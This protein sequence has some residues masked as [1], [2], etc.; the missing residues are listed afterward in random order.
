M[1]C[2]ELF[3]CSPVDDD[4]LVE[5]EGILIDIFICS[6]KKRSGLR[7][8]ITGFLFFF[9]LSVLNLGPTV[10]QLKVPP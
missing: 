6:A 3:L 2:A 8:D 10:Y 7:H 9:F 5:C 1:A 4:H